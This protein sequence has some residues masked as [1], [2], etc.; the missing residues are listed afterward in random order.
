ME[1]NVPL[2]NEEHVYFTELKS[3]RWTVLNYSTIHKHMTMSQFILGNQK[4]WKFW[5][6][7]IN[8]SMYKSM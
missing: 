2:G 7:E 8:K 3:E 4:F 6:L 5:I 1:E